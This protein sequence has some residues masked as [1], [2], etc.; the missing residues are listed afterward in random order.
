MKIVALDLGQ[1]KSVA[2]VDPA[3]QAVQVEDEVCGV[4][5]IVQS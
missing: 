4:N 2:C 3:G 5:A 1:S